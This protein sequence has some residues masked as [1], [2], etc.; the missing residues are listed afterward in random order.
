MSPH[1]SELNVSNAGHLSDRI[2]DSAPFQVSFGSDA[3]GLTLEDRKALQRSL[4]STG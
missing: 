4:T 3:T 2:A 1:S